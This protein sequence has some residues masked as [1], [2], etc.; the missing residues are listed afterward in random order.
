MNIALP[1]DHARFENFVSD[2]FEVN[3]MVTTVTNV[4]YCR[5]RP[6]DK[7]SEQIESTLRRQHRQLRRLQLNRAL[8]ILAQSTT[9]ALAAIDD[10]QRGGS[11][12]S[13]RA[14]LRCL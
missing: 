11:S 6:E 1:L 7:L 13:R 12:K 5:V 14:Y 2:E 9:R 3:L 8:A 4:S 10:H